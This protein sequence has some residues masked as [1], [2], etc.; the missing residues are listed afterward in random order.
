MKGNRDDENI[1][2]QKEMTKSFIICLSA[3][4]KLKKVQHYTLEEEQIRVSFLVGK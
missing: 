1:V 2:A 4:L 3:K